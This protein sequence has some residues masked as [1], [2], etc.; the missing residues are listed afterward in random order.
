MATLSVSLPNPNPNP[1]LNPPSPI[2]ALSKSR[3][4][5]ENRATRWN[6]TDMH[7]SPRHHGLYHDHQRHEVLTHRTDM[8]DTCED[9]PRM[10][11]FRLSD[12]HGDQGGDNAET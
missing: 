3:R 8:T 10:S 12:F 1:N 4:R 7:W 11:D 9:T 2:Q 6:D 5:D